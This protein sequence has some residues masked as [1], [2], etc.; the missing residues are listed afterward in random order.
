MSRQFEFPYN[1]DKKLIQTLHILDPIGETINCIYIPPYLKDYQ[2]IL[3]SSEQA[4]LL[5]NMTREE[6]E[7]HINFINKLFPGKIQ[8]LLQKQNII[9]DKEKINYYISLGITKFCSGSIEQSKII[10]NIDKSLN[11]I[12]SISMGIDKEK[13]IKNLKEYKLYF[14][15]FVLPFKFSRDIEEIKKLPKDFYYILLINAYCN[16]K[17]TGQAHWN[18][19]YKETPKF[20]CPG[21]LKI[22]KNFNSISWE[23]SARIRPMDL[24]YFDKYIQIYKLQDRGWPT[25]QILKDYILYTTNYEMYPNIIYDEKIYKKNGN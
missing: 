24:G 17:C 9:L 12:G 22:N 21:L 4:A 14:D 2:T 5:D 20:K 15:G 13:I 11:V 7:E 16:I 8:L 23:E 25:D 10:K 6:Y 3:R 1:F 18:F 19:D